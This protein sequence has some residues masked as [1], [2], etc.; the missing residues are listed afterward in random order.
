MASKKKEVPQII[1]NIVSQALDD[2][3]SDRFA[4]YAKYVIQD[5]AIPD[6]RDGLKPVQRR[7]IYS[8]FTNGN[9]FEKPT[10]KC[11][12]IVGDVMGRFHPHGDS[13]IY[14]ALTR[15]SQSWKMS[16]CLVDFQ[17]NNGSIDGDPAAAYRYT[18]ARLSKYSMLLVKNI[19]KDTVDFT[20]NFSDEELEPIVL[21]SYI[22]NLFVNGSKGIAVGLATEIPPHNL[23]EICNAAI[24]R[25]NNPECT[26]DD[27]LIDLKGPDFPT[28][29]IIYDNGGIR[30]IYETGRGKFE[31]GSKFEIKEVSDGTQIIINEIPYG[32][33]KQELVHSIDEI[34]RDKEVNGIVD[35][36]DLSS[37]DDIDIVVD[38]KKDIDPKIIIQYLYKKTNLKITYNANIVA[39]CNNHPKTLSLIEYLD[40]YLDHL[41]NVNKK[42]LTYDLNKARKRLNIVYG[43]IKAVSII[44]EIINLIRN[45]INK[46]D[47]KKKLVEQYRFNEDQAEAILNIRLYKLSH[48]DVEIYLNERDE[49][50]RTINKI[51]ALLSSKAKL[52]KYI[53][54]DLRKISEEYSKGR[55]T[56]ISDKV[57]NININKRDL[58]AK[59][60]FYVVITKDGYIKRSSV[61]SYKAC[62]GQL[63]GIKEGDSIVLAKL[64]SSLDYVL[65]FTNAGNYLFIPAHEITENKWKDE[66]V[67]V[68][69]IVTLPNNEFIIKAIIV[70]DFNIDCSIGLISKNGQIKKTK[71]PE[72]FVSR[73]SKP[74]QCMKLLKNDEMVDVAVLSNNNDVLVVTESGVGTFFNEQEITAT[75]LKTSGIKAIS[76]LRGSLLK[77]LIPLKND[78]KEKIMFITDGGMYRNYDSSNLTLTKRLGATQTIFKSFKSDPHKLIGYRIIDNKIENIDIYGLFDNNVPFKFSIS[79]YHLTPI[80]KYCKRNIEEMSDDRKIKYIYRFDAVTID[81]NFKVDIV[82]NPIVEEAI[83]EENSEQYEQISIFD[84]MGD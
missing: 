58:I 64:I 18:E 72:F 3:M 68:N 27:L 29:G 26:L 42:A 52:T 59:E 54:E 19:E 66:G 67:H 55:R 15:M 57:E 11:A 23:A 28:G 71:L 81:E 77:A 44:D 36:K 47:A 16:E 17:G 74:V 60:D 48:T 20:L 25:L 45:S 62:E 8:M 84:D 12:K 35:V 69:S 43:L 61:K 1:E 80:D 4:V 34:K 83:E 75:G 82:E 14:D 73:Y 9:T 32:I 53:S 2:L 50:E 22:P 56:E 39:I 46:D 21:P 13:S 78:V 7:I 24:T 33:E 70:K 10:R 65:A 31:I 76:T 63:P 51:A 30:Q 40:I 5:R 6:A 41:I 38:L 49:L 79:D 37:G